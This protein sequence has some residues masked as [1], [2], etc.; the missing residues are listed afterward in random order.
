MYPFLPHL[1]AHFTDSV[2]ELVDVNIGV[3][4]TILPK[5]D[6]APCRQTWPLR[7]LQLSFATR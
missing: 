1:V 7:H 5:V 2:R 4:S 3:G 6:F